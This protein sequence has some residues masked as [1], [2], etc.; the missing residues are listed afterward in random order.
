MKFSILLTALAV[1]LIPSAASAEGTVREITVT[2]RAEVRVVPDEV[3]LNV[4]VE[5]MNEKLRQA[6]WENDEKVAYVFKVIRSLGL[7]ADQVK[8]DFINIEPVYENSRIETKFLGFKVKTAIVI[9]FQKID[10]IADVL[11]AVLEVGVNRVSGLNFQTTEFRQHRD[12]AMLMA[13]DAAKV[14]AQEMAERLGSKIGKPVLITEGVQDRYPRVSN[15][16]QSMESIGYWMD[17][18]IAPGQLS[19]P[20]TVSVTFELLD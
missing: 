16:I 15:T 19:I 4:A 17:G 14:K 12:R 6:K 8:T 11:S 7:D 20:A 13:L 3:V 10:L 18:P 5:T 2:G 9:T 1:L